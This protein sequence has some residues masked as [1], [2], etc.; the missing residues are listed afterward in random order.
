MLDDAGWSE[1][2]DERWK[3][4]VR[5]EILKYDPSALEADIEYTLELVIW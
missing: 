2:I 5:N 1:I 4:D 3:D